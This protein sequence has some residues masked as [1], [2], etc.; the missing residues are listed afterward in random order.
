MTAQEN[1]CLYFAYKSL[2]IAFGLGQPTAFSKSPFGIEK[3]GSSITDVSDACLA[4]VVEPSGGT[5][6]GKGLQTSCEPIPHVQNLSSLQPT[7]TVDS[8]P[9]QV[10]AW[11]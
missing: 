6:E 9:L 4:D 7:L 10:Q 2:R 1:V 5:Q 11:C 3:H 8:C